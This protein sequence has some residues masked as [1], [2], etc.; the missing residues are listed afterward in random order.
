M[1][2][3]TDQEILEWLEAE[4]GQRFSGWDFSYL[5]GR[6]KPLG[7]LPWSF[8]TTARNALSTATSV[9]DVDTGGGER[10]ANLL[11]TSA[12]SGSASATE[13]YGPNVALAKGNL[14]GLS[15]R[16]HDTSHRSADFADNSFDLI[17]DR[18]GG[19]IACSDIYNMLQPGGCYVTQQVGEKTNSELRQLF[20]VE[21]TAASDFSLSL[22]HAVGI[23]EPLGFSIEIAEEH[24][25]PVRFYDVGALVYYL[26]A[27]P[28]EVPGFELEKFTSKLIELHRVTETR[29]Y[30]IDASF[31]SVFVVATKPD[32]TGFSA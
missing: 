25:Y 23:L 2:A 30:A 14:N 7:E 15:V 6:R 31:H 21:R 32:S 18:H 16:L 13:S 3:K 4:Y 26:Q 27:V 17:L 19:S 5:D 9:L 28:W 12:F 24:L 29:G 20:D 8:A 22:N 11:L 1:R 10:F